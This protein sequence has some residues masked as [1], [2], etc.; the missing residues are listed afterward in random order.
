MVIK[1]TYILK[2][3]RFLLHFVF[4]GWKMGVEADIKFVFLHLTDTYNHGKGNVRTTT[5]L[6]HK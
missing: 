6:T 5:T 4:D 2:S 1:G 3:I